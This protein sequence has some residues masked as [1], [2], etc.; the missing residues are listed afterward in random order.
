MDGIAHF[1]QGYAAAI[2]RHGGGET[3]L[4]QL[5]VVF[6]ERGE[7]VRHAHTDKPIVDVLV[8]GRHLGDDGAVKMVF[9]QQGNMGQQLRTLQF[10]TRSTHVDGQ[11]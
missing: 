1:F 5:A 9:G 3:G 6:V 10:L 7:V 8:D 11:G 2:L 4:T